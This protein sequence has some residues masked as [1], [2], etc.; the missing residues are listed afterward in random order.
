MNPQLDNFYLELVVTACQMGKGRIW[1]QGDLEIR[2]NSEGKPYVDS[3][4]INISEFLD[5][6]EAE[7]E[8]EIFS[9]C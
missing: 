2:F 3:D 4:I 7:G 9:C 6:L 8:F 5:S 1:M